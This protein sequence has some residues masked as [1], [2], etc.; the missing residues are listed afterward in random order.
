M[1]KN[2][3]LTLQWRHNG[4]DCVPNYE[5]HD[6][7]APRHWSLCEEFIGDRLIPR[8]P[9]KWPV[10]RKMF[11]DVIMIF[12]ISACIAPTVI[13]LDICID[14]IVCDHSGYLDIYI[15]SMHC[16]NS[17]YLNTFTSNIHCDI[18]ISVLIETKPLELRLLFFHMLLKIC[19]P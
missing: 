4:C 10:T 6:C 1:H 8:S 17:R 18:Q 12:G 19:I 13:F 15:D 16:N 11:D 3:S 5:P 14:S 9:Y 7:L 2:Y